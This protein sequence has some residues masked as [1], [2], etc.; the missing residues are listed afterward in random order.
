MRKLNITKEAYDKSK[1]FTSKYGKLEYVSES[2]KIYK[3]DKGKILKF[4]ESESGEVTIQWLI[5]DDVLG[6]VAGNSETISVDLDLIDPNDSETLIDAIKH[7][8]KR[9]YNGMSFSYDDDFI[10]ENE[11]EFWDSLGVKPNRTGIR[12]F[13]EDTELF[14]MSR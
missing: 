3:T 6:I 5:D 13:D 14:G 10:I 2:G 4:N 8:M 7:E 9:I 1:Y 12:D 11:D